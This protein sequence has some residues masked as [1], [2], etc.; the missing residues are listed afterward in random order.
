[1]SQS[2]R[3]AV[4]GLQTRTK[5][6]HNTPPIGFF[7]HIIFMEDISGRK[8]VPKANFNLAR[9]FSRRAMFRI[10]LEN[11]YYS[12]KLQSVGRRF[13]LDPITC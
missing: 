13:K 1:M 3:P 4:M 12:L 10:V 2:G 5:Q 6:I 9:P 8:Q 7:N 11:L